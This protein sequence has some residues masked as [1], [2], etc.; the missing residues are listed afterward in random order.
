[1]LGVRFRPGG[2]AALTG[3]SAG[4]LR[5]RFVPLAQVF[6]TAAL[7]DVTPAEYAAQCRDAPV[8]QR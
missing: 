3:R 2:F 5:D 1:V 7:L 6:G 8:G 4:G